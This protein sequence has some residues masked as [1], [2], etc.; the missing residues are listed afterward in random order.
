MTSSQFG[1]SHSSISRRRG[2]YY[3]RCSRILIS[4]GSE[5]LYIDPILLQLKENVQHGMTKT[6]EFM[7]EGLLQCQNILCVPDVDE[8]RK[9]IIIEEHHSTYY[10]HSG[11]TKIYHDLKKMYWQGYMKKNIAKF[12]AQCPI[13]QRVKLRH[14]N[15]RGYMQHIELPIWKWDMIN[16]D[17]VTGLPYSF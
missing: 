2:Y 7:Q 9:R 5:R 1:D 6:I 11:S 13:F 17:F 10:V 14:Q 4:N 8:L 12:V 3:A 15:P 16:M